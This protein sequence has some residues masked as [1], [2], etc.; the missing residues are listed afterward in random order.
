MNIED[1]FSEKSRGRRQ[2]LVTVSSE[3]LN[4]NLDKLHFNALTILFLK[5]PCQ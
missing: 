2:Q 4:V 5:C 1:L 3:S